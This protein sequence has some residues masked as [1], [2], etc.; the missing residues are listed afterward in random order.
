MYVPILV[1]ASDH[2]NESLAIV[3]EMMND[4]SGLWLITDQRI[5]LFRSRLRALSSRSRPVVE[6]MISIAERGDRFWPT[7]AEYYA[8]LA[9]I[10]TA[11]LQ[12]SKQ[13]VDVVIASMIRGSRLDN[14][15]D[16]EWVKQTLEILREISASK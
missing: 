3:G 7:K 5:D 12:V 8:A 4:R 15:S 2:R 13:Q 11:S 16:R 6:E 9:E 14:V 10:K 1:P